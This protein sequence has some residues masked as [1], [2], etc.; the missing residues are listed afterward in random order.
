MSEIKTYSISDA[1][2]MIS[3]TDSRFKTMRISVDMIVPLASSTAAKYGILPSLVTRATR[4]FPDYTALSRKLAELYGASLDCGVRKLGTYQILSVSVSGISSK[5]AFD[6]EDMFRELSEML[7][8]VLFHPLKDAN[9]DFPLENFTQ[10]KRQLLELKDSEFN[11]KILYAHRRCEQLLFSDETAGISKHGSREEIEALSLAD[12]RGMW[13][14]LLSHARFEIFTMGDCSPDPT[15]FQKAFQT[16]GNNVS[17][18]F[19]SFAKPKEVKMEEEACPVSQS[20]LSM[21]FRVDF[22]PEE[23]LLFQLLNAVF[24]G[25][26]SSKL[27]QNVREKQS[28][29]YYCSSSF[30][31]GCRAIYVESGVENDKITVTEEAVLQQLTDLQ[32]GDLSEEVLEA[33][34]MAICNAL[35]SV[36][37]SLAAV[38]NWCI[39]H[40]F[41]EEIPTPEAAA[42]AI[43][44]YTIEDVVAAAKKVYPAAVFTL[45]G[46]GEHE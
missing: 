28:L 11:D 32:N 5:Y 39:G 26:P 12:L 38:E 41:E 17:C 36:Y 19:L 42:S 9:G 1:V 6:G 15:L 20:K 2:K 18:S 46:S 37:D 8:D 31:A 30:D 24:G 35:F 3:F 43:R 33:A 29:C 22:G 10:E 16:V 34:K 14:E 40:L 23:R 13:E 45:K 21:A 25:I 27:F 4:D 44:A 7:F